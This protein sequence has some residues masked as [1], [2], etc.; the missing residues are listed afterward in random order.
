[1]HSPAGEPA[2]QHD[3]SLDEERALWMEYVAK[4]TGVL[5]VRLIERYLP[6]SRT[7]AAYMF[8]RRIDRNAEFDDYLQYARI[9]LLE[10][11]DRYDPMREARFVTYASHRMRG[12]ILNGVLRSTEGAAVSRYRRTLL[13]QR[14]ESLRTAGGDDVFSQMVDR[15]IGVALGLILD[16]VDPVET[17][18]GLDPYRSFQLLNLKK[19]VTLV[20][21][22]LPERERMIIRW[23]YFDQMDF[24]LVGEAL[25][26]SK[27]RISQLHSR[28]LRLLREGLHDLDRM[29][30][31]I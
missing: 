25:Q 13:Q 22:A 10:A 16:S 24:K 2:E 9:G 20:V 28:A 7:L 6:E 12:A 21:E 1:M 30:I 31:L 8:G 11:I 3:S 29:D 5:R 14:M 23:H 19:R 26:L 17:G 27:G 15:T 18:S 4:R